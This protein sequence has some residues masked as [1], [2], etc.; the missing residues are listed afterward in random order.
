M[1]IETPTLWEKMKTASYWRNRM[2]ELAIAGFAVFL[3]TSYYEQQAKRLKAAV[4]VTDWFEVNEL[5]V[6]DH[7]FASNP[8]MIYD[9]EVK[10]NVRGFWVAEAQ[11]RGD[12]GKFSN[13]CTG[14]ATNDYDVEEEIPE[15]VVDW[16]WFLFRK[17]DIPPGTYRLSVSWDFSRPG[18]PIKQYRKNSNI[19][20]VY[21]P[22]KVE[23]FR[24]R[25]ELPE[26]T[27]LDLLIKR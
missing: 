17:C 23:A 16:E 27:P 5:F 8:Q 26:D 2:F 14:S 10:E 12:N 19:F 20:V 9:R 15:D 6:P 25:L 21:D 18:F 11:R 7:A 3:L 4:D 1:M 24:E 13:A 22:V